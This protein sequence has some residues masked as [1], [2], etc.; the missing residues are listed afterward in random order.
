MLFAHSPGKGGSPFPDKF[1][2]G[3]VFDTREE[4]GS[5]A[6]KNNPAEKS[7]RLLAIAPK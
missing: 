6:K 4:D 3:I 7:A 5:S 2:Q 1:A